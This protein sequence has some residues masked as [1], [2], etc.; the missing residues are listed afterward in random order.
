MVEI[1]AQLFTDSEANEMGAEW[2]GC[3][4]LPQHIAVSLRLTVR[5]PPHPL[6]EATPSPEAQP[7]D[8]KKAVRR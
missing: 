8:N 3:A 1:Q 2:V 7:Q 4:A 6:G 5:A